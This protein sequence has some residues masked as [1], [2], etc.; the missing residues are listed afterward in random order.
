MLEKK[1]LKWYKISILLLNKDNFTMDLKIELIDDDSSDV[2][3]IEECLIQENYPCAITTGCNTNEPKRNGEPEHSLQCLVVKISKE[4][5][6]PNI[7]IGQLCTT[8]SNRYKYFKTIPMGDLVRKIKD[9]IATEP[10]FNKYEVVLKRRR[11]SDCDDEKHVKRLKLENH[12]LKEEGPKMTTG[13]VIVL[14]DEDAP[15][16]DSGELEMVIVEDDKKELAKYRIKRDLST[17]RK[18]FVSVEVRTESNENEAPEYPPTTS[19]ASVSDEIQ[20]E[21]SETEDKR[22]IKP[23]IKAENMLSADVPA[24]TRYEEA[25]EDSKKD[26]KI[27]LKAAFK[28]ENSIVD[29]SMIEVDEELL[30]SAPSN[31]EALISVEIRSMG[32]QTDNDIFVAVDSEN[33]PTQKDVSETQKSPARTEGIHSTGMLVSLNQ[34]FFLLS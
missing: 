32:T 5:K 31:P 20:N 1:S 30:E 7:E 15:L 13:D 26:V 8:L 2:E 27:K 10:Y 9:I 22:D 25:Q 34:F 17:S 3:L 6:T 29:G 21:G 28:N 23:K 24:R 16:L 14:D 18:A 4:L 33:M 12:I 19:S 11:S